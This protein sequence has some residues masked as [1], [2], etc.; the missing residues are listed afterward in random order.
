MRLALTGRPAT[1]ALSPAD[2]AAVQSA[3]ASL[4]PHTCA[5]APRPSA[6]FCPA[7]LPGRSLLAC[8]VAARKNALC[9]NAPTASCRPGQGVQAMLLCVCDTCVCQFQTLRAPD[10]ARPPA[11]RSREP[12]G[13]APGRHGRPA[14]AGRR[15]HPAGRA[16]HARGR[17]GAAAAMHL[18]QPAQ[19]DGCGACVAVVEGEACPCGHAPRRSLCGLS[20]TLGIYA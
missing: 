12:G 2:L 1:S 18:R 14:A 19:L 5:P 17:H 10:A 15:A 4:L 6:C 13:S 20:M 3:V 16:D 7:W 9:E 11:P 8:A